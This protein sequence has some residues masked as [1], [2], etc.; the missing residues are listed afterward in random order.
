MNELNRLRDQLRPHLPWHGARLNFICL[1]L[2]A[3]FQAKTVNLAELAT[4]FA[5]PVKIDSNY[6]RLQRFFRHF[7]L[8][9]SD[10]ARFVVRLI[11]IPQPWTLSLDRT[12]W[13]FGQTHFN[14]L[15]L[16]VVHE[17]IAFPLLWTMLDKKGNSNSDERMDLFDRFEALFPDV[18]VAC[19]TADREFVGAEWLSYLLLDPKI[20]FRLRIRHSELISSKSGKTRRSGTRMFDSLRPGESRQLTGRRWVWRRKVYVIGSRLA[21]SGELLILITDARPKTAMS[22]YARR[23]GIENLFGALKTRGFCLESTHFQDA[24]RLSRLLGLLSLAFTWAMKVGLWSHQRSPIPLKFHGRRSKSL[25]RTGFDF[26]RR[27]FSNLPLFRSEFL[28]ALQLLSC[29]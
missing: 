1:F 16:G 18:E 27:T 19:L 14:I 23:W 5:R 8:D 9:L 4:C 10:I 12:N 29:T 13:S 20:P 22:D 21:D 6:K 15:M 26:L 3:L 28:Q 24:Q 7:D 17:G 11:N 25:F 2:M